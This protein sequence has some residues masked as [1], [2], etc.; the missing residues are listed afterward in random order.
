LS[1]ENK[2]VVRRLIEEVWNN[3]NLDVIDEVISEDHVDHDPAQAGSP[4]GREGMRA[5][6]K[7]YRSA[8][9]DTHLE[10]GEMV[11]EGDLVAAPWTATGT[12]Q[13]ELM[14]IAPT[15][16]SVTVTGMGMDRVRNGQIV[17]S[18]ANYDALGMLAQLGAIPAPAGATT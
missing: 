13:G 7:M 11:A 6:V 15:G 4:G 16:R 9:P 2:A 12:H 1:E 17:E 5:F 3:G 18:W 10:L 14:G 8:Y